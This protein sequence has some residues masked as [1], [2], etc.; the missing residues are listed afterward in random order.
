MGNGQK[1]KRHKLQVKDDD[2]VSLDPH[3]AL[4]E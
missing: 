1:V 3:F 2:F 4:L